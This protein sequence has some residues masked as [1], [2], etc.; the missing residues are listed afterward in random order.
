MHSLTRTV[1]IALIAV[2]FSAGAFAQYSQPVRDV[3]NP[4]RTPF[5]GFG[6][7]TIPLHFINQ[8]VSVGTIPAGQRLVI[9]HVAATCSADADDSISNVSVSVYKG[10]PS[11]WSSVGVP[12]LAQKQGVTWTGSTTWTVSQPVRLYSDG[13]NSA[14]N[15]NISHSKTTATASCFV[16]VTGHTITM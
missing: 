7:V 13:V 1:M 15:V 10:T 11:S 16:V 4:A 2:L 6:S 3:E 9:E 14:T 12:V 8:I 5:L